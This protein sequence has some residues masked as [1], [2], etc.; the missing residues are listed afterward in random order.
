M[1]VVCVQVSAMKSTG[2]FILLRFP[3]F[4]GFFRDRDLQV[5]Q[6]T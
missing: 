1:N 2:R 3:K 5:D 4:G 6:P